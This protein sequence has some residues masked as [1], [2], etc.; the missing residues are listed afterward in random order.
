MSG[1][2]GCCGQRGLPYFG[3]HRAQRRR[4]RRQRT[5]ALLRGKAI[6]V[7]QIKCFLRGHVPARFVGGSA[8]ASIPV[9]R[10]P[11]ARDDGPEETLAPNR[12][13]RIVDEAKRATTREP[14]DCAARNSSARHPCCPPG[15]WSSRYH[16][17]SRLHTFPCL[18]ESPGALCYRRRPVPRSKRLR[19]RPA[20]RR[21]SFRKTCCPLPFPATAVPPR[22]SEGRLARAFYLGMLMTIPR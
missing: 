21:C 15:S 12:P 7:C 3:A 16:S 4:Q 13:F 22:K 14:A 10:P 9:R 6:G 11:A 5:L 18:P 19:P 1:Q 20:R 2:S 17:R 8:S